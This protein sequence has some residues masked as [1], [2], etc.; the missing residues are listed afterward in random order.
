MPRRSKPFFF[1]SWPFASA[2]LF[3]AGGASCKTMEPEPSIAS[4]HPPVRLMQ[5]GG[6]PVSR[7][8]VSEGQP[9]TPRGNA[10]SRASGSPSLIMGGRRWRRRTRPGPRKIGVPLG[11]SRLGLGR[12]ELLH[13]GAQAAW[14]HSSK[15]W[16]RS[17]RPRLANS[18]PI[19]RA[20]GNLRTALVGVIRVTG[21]L[22]PNRCGLDRN[23]TYVQDIL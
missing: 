18:F 6:G 7:N 1:P 14:L 5:T 12:E 8:Q 3:R 22:Q 20:V 10:P 2:H 21:N 15:R 11:L 4:R 19:S 9:E 23:A 13:W 17:P 16:R